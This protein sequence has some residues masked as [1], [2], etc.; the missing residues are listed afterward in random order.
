[1]PG[2]RSLWK[3]SSTRLA[4]LF[5]IQHNINFN[6]YLTRHAQWDWWDVEDKKINDYAA[7]NG[8]RILS[9]YKVVWE[10]KIWIITEADRSVTTI[11]LPEE[12]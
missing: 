11:L 8:E 6:D 10:Q 4:Q 7:E 3:L 1:M 2:L 9:I 5:A 12:Y